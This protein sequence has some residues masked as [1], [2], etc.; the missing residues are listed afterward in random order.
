MYMYVPTCLYVHHLRAG[1]RGQKR[2]LDSLKLQ[3]WAPDVGT[4]NQTWVHRKSS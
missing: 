4:G 3:L 2:G 1:I